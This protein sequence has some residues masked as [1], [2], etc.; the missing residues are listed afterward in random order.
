VNEGWENEDSKALVVFEE[1]KNSTRSVSSAR[2]VL[3]T[4][5][6]FD[7]ETAITMTILEEREKL[8]EGAPI[9]ED[10]INEVDDEVQELPMIGA[11][12]DDAPEE[13]R[14]KTPR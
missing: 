10:E 2:V 14:R 8:A 4:E 9:D 5:I 11:P 13:E 1:T 7:E 3:E 12:E 6:K